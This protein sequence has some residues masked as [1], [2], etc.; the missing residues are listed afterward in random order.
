MKKRSRN[1]GSNIRVDGLP[2]TLRSK[3]NDVSVQQPGAYAKCLLDPEHSSPVSIPDEANYPTTVFTTT[4]EF[5]IPLTTILGAGIRM[6]LHAATFYELESAASTDGTYAYGSA[7]PVAWETSFRANY[8]AVRLVACSLRIE[9]AGTDAANSGI[10]TATTFARSSTLANL[11]VEP[12][13]MFLSN[14]TTQRNC[15]DTYVGPAK[16]GAN[17]IYRPVDSASFRL[18][19]ADNATDPFGAFQVHISK[20]TAGAQYTGYL[21][22]HWE[23]LSK[24]PTSTTILTNPEVTPLVNPLEMSLVSSLLPAMPTVAS[25][26]ESVMGILS[27]NADA[28]A[29]VVRKITGG[30]DALSMIAA[31]APHLI[32]GFKAAKKARR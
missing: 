16:D 19:L 30:S 28:F 26:L 12:T 11:Q 1:I 21:T 31:A 10:I 8:Q 3:F 13:T 14:Q 25:G 15:R 24:N 22:M 32:S 2:P 17:L 18:V 29:E 5:D 23:G 6:N 9:Y 27:Q 4:S 20:A 7:V